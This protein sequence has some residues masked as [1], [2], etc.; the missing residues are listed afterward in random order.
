MR[1]LYVI[2]YSG[3]VERRIAPRFA[4]LLFFKALH[5]VIGH[6]SCKSIT[7]YL[8]HILHSSPTIVPSEREVISHD[9]FF[10]FDSAYNLPGGG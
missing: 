5:R 3:V 4:L 7:H 2:Y 9:F 1:A 6:Y 10:L 8:L